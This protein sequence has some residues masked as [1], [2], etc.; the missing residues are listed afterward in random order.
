MKI[1]RFT[2]EDAIMQAWGTKEDIGLLME[3]LLDGPDPLTEDQIANALL[4]IETLHDMRCQKLF[5]VFSNLIQQGE[6]NENPKAFTDTFAESFFRSQA[7][8]D[9]DSDD[10]EDDQRGDQGGQDAGQTPR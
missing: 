1:T 9:G 3:R 2:L 8:G 10:K 7:P 4:G 6:F 5:E